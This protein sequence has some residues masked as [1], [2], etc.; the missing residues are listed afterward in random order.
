[1]WLLRREVSA[2]AG[3][4]AMAAI[5]GDRASGQAVPR[6]GQSRAAPRGD[7]EGSTSMIANDLV[8]LR[9]LCRI[10]LD[11]HGAAGFLAGQEDALAEEGEGRAAVH[12]AFEQLGSGVEAFDEAGVPGQGQAVA[13]G[14][15]VLAD[16]G[17]EGVELGLVIGVDGGHPGVEPAAVAAGED[18]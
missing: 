8:P 15:V 16:P 1:M 4:L 18:L 5:S 9:G 7:A 6:L 12:L 3:F 17:G 2:E 14:G 10:S 13:D 11:G